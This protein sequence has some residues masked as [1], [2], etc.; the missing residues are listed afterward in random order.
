MS[1]IRGVKDRQVKFTQ[2]MNSMFED[3]DLS[4][5]AKGFVG[6]CLTKTDD[7]QFRMPHL[8]NALKEGE[9]ALYSIINE[10]IE[11]GYAYR[12]QVKGA[13]NRIIGWETVVSDSKA[14]IQ[15]IKDEIGPTNIYQPHRCFAELES[16]E[17][18]G[19]GTSNIVNKSNTK[20]EQQQAAP[21]AVVFSHEKEKKATKPVSSKK[22]AVDDDDVPIYPSLANLAITD[23][24]KRYLSK[25]FT[26]GRVNKAV[27]LATHQKTKIETSLIQFLTWACKQDDIE[28][29]ADALDAVKANKAKAELCDGKVNGSKTTKIE[30]LK[31]HVEF[32]HLTSQR[33]PD[34][35]KYSQKD[36]KEAFLA[37]LK[38]HKFV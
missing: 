4:L 7:W 19:G 8:C 2:I 26:E 11:L 33:A 22:P 9:R 1:T 14:E 29:P 23:S 16:A 37:L 28:L 27:A 12:Y 17:L 30:V 35:L 21:A 31:G 3:K 25:T 18:H 32:V 6:Y 15:R 38:K 24:Q 5:R 36:F 20:R 10:C 34:I 13:K